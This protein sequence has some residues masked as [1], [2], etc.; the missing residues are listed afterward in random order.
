MSSNNSKTNMINIYNRNNSYR[1]NIKSKS[2]RD[3][4]MNNNKEKDNKKN[5]NKKSGNDIHNNNIYIETPHFNMSQSSPLSSNN[6]NNYNME[7]NDIIKNSLNLISSTISRQIFSNRESY[8]NYFDLQ[9]KIIVESSALLHDERRM[10]NL[11]N[12]L[13]KKG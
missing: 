8:K 6:N 5:Y 2:L 7:N 4:I 9:K 3:I 11:A 13:N 10:K 1:T 12:A